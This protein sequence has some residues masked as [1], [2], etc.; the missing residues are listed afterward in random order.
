MATAA[1]IS[2]GNVLSINASQQYAPYPFPMMGAAR[3]GSADTQIAPPNVQ[4]TVSVIVSW[5]IAR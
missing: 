1:G 2:L 3:A 5:A 4:L